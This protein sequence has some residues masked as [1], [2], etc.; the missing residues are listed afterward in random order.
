MPE[1]YPLNVY[2]PTGGLLLENTPLICGG[3]EFDL[4]KE[5]HK[6]FAFVY[7]GQWIEVGNTITARRLAASIL[8]KSDTLWVTGGMSNG[9]H[10]NTTELVTLTESTSRLQDSPSYSV[11][12]VRAPDLP[13][14]AERH[15]L[16]KLNA[17]TAFLIGGFPNPSQTYF[18]DLNTDLGEPVFDSAPGPELITA[19]YRHACGLLV[20]PGDGNDAVVVVTGGFNDSHVILTSK[21]EMWIPGTDQWI[22]GP[23]LPVTL[24]YHAGLTSPDGKSLY[25]V[26]GSDGSILG[27][28]S[29]IYK[30]S[31]NDGGWQ[32][33]RLDQELQVP[34]TSHV[35]M[36]I[37]GS[38]A[39]CT[40]L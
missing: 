13:L 19:R 11:S 8:W 21:T 37:P 31:F 15:C 39:N 26:G 10:L 6:C 32:W 38:L 7:P 27:Y 36:V 1:D 14:P 33:S 25:L 18:L 9:R 12:S 16:V 2:Q 29:S 17:S 22:N 28:Q 4:D 30:L 35:A 3:Y 23:D 20:E 5:R 34:R 24:S 40:R